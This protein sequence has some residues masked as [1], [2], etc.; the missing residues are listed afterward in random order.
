[1]ILLV[2]PGTNGNLACGY[3]LQAYGTADPDEDGTVQVNFTRLDR[4]S[5]RHIREQHPD[6]VP[7]R[8]VP[9]NAPRPSNPPTVGGGEPPTPT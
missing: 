7:R 4:Q 6:F 3:K 9:T 1:M 5:Q 8:K 2:C